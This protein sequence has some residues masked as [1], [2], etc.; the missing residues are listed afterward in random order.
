MPQRYLFDF[1]REKIDNGEGFSP[2]G[3]A[4]ACCD[5]FLFSGS[6]DPVISLK[7]QSFASL[8]KPFD[9]DSNL[10]EHVYRLVVV[11]LRETSF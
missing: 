9:V 5:N 10:R 7:S 8:D 2:G 6:I 11:G 4:A 3:E 1:Q